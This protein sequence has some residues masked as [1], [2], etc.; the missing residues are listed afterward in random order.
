MLVTPRRVSLNPV[1]TPNARTL[2]GLS[3]VVVGLL[4]YSR[5]LPA[6][7]VGTP[8]QTA[9]L[10]VNFGDESGGFLAPGHPALFDVPEFSSR[11]WTWTA[12]AEPTRTAT[13][14][15]LGSS[16]YDNDASS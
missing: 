13:A 16:S 9:S 15:A 8:A 3:W 10:V 2:A 14:K 1:M 4:T 5:I 7:S 12:T 6:A 11:R